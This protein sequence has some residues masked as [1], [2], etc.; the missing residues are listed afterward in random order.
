MSVKPAEQ[1]GTL[2]GCEVK[3]LLPPRVLRGEGGGVL[4]CVCV[5]EKVLT[6]L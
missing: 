4:V 6:I 5:C 2:A 3:Y 1:S